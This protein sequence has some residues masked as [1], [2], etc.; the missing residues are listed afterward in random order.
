[1]FTLLAHTHTTLGQRCSG[2]P[3][4]WC[5]VSAN[6]ASGNITCPCLARTGSTTV[7]RTAQTSVVR[8]LG[9]RTNTAGGVHQFRRSLRF[10][11]PVAQW[12]SGNVFS[13]RSF[14]LPSRS[15]EVCPRVNASPRHVLSTRGAG[16]YSTLARITRTAAP[17]PGTS[18]MNVAGLQ[19]SCC[20][21]VVDVGP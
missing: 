18:R 2:D 20:R 12:P 5:R 19:F 7:A 16:F 21:P 6:A 4:F 15:S 8:V 10:K 11:V 17:L 13:G 14:T 3:P 9:G 1:M